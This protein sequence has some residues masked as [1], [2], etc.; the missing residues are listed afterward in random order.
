MQVLYSE[1]IGAKHGRTT[2]VWV[3]H[4]VDDGCMPLSRDDGD[5]RFH[6]Q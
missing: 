2:K 1:R 5:T 3:S 4:Q 6:Q